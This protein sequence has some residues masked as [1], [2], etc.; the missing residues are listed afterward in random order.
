ME[1]KLFHALSI[2]N[3]VSLLKP[4]LANYDG[5]TNRVLSKLNG[6]RKRIVTDTLSVCLNPSHVLFDEGTMSFIKSLSEICE[7]YD[8]VLTPF[9]R[10]RSGA[11]NQ[12]ELLQALLKHARALYSILY[13]Q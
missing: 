1:Q 5:E 3:I 7:G 11:Y 10:E 4:N 2:C 8:E 12:P 9:E 13:L 6:Y